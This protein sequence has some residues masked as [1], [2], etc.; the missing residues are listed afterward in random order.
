MKLKKYANSK[1]I[2][3]IGDMP[4]YVAYD[5]VEAWT[6]PQNFILDENSKPLH[7]AGVPP[8]YFS[9][10]G[11]LWGN[12]VYNWE[13]LEKTKFEWWIE[14]VS[15][16]LKLYDIIRIDHFRGLSAYWS[17]PYGEK[18]AVKGKWVKASGKKMFDAL[19]KEFTELP[20]IAED[21]G[22]ITPD[23]EELRDHFDFPGMKI[24]QFAFDSNEENEY[25]PHTFNTNCVVYTGTHD[26]NT[27][28][29]W[30]DSI[31]AKDKKFVKEY[32]GSLDEGISKTLIRMAWASKADFSIAP[33]QDLLDLD[34]KAR[35]NLPGTHSK[36][37]IW[38][39]KHNDLNAEHAKWLKEL[40]KTYNR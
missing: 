23:V 26:N 25:L 6:S 2:K 31:S 36:N 28:K 4:L 33:L 19:K 38:K 24:L 22:V 10:T 34:E 7:V 11:Q 21:L 39:F 29:G 13:H 40:T 35:M 1:G 27:T 9:K 12:P 32:I 30:F 16:N 37:W 20:F 8:D 14:R 3:I 15:A 17:I 5:S 18:T